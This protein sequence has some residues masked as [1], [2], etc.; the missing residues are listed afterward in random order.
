MTPPPSRS[1]WRERGSV[2]ML[3]PA[4]VL[5]VLVLGSIAVDFAVVHLAERELAAAAAAA[6]NDAVAAGLDEDHFRETGRVRL[7]PS[8][9]EAAARASLARQRPS[10][11]ITAATISVDPAGRVTVELEGT[12]RHVIAPALPGLSDETAIGA[13]ATA[14]AATG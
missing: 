13:R 14:S 11:A 12:A 7:D 9:T 8:V 10:F 2:M 5:V 3:F 6:A 4:S 1:R